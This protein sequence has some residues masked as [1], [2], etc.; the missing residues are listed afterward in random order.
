MTI[1]QR[2]KAERERKGWNIQWLASKANM[3]PGT[4]YNYELEISSPSWNTA[5]KI[6]NSMG[7]TIELKQEVST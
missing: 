7:L 5:E 1:G 3:N 2:I 6:F 4:I